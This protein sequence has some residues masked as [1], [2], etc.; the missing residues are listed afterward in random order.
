MAVYFLPVL[1][2]CTVRPMNT[3]SVVACRPIKADQLLLSAVMFMV[4]GKAEGISIRVIAV[5]PGG[6]G[7]IL[8]SLSVENFESFCC[9]EVENGHG[10]HIMLSIGSGALRHHCAAAA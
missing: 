5:L 1:C 6:L 4:D 8:N 7:R 10:M 3:M 2:S 9:E